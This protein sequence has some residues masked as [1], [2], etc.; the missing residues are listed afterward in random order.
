[1]LAICK[2]IVEAHGGRIWVESTAG[3]GAAFLFSLPPLRRPARGKG[4]AASAAG[5][6]QPIVADAPRHDQ[7]R[8]V[9]PRPGCPPQC[10]PS[11]PPGLTGQPDTPRSGQ[12][13]S[14]GGR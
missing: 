14:P 1:G 3:Q 11:S 8:L 12:A 13:S 7:A 6:R 9:L 2:K 5:G 10:G 4:A